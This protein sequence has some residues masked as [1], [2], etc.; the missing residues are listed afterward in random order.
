[1]KENLLTLILMMITV[2]LAGELKFHPFNDT[3]RVSLGTPVFFFF[4]LWIRKIPLIL[5][6]FMVGILVVVFRILFDFIINSGTQL[7]YDFILHSPTFFYYLT[8]ASFFSLIKVNKL[9]DRPLLVG[10][11]SVFTE[12]ISSLTELSIRHFFLE[13]TITLSFLGQI[14]II[15]VIRSFFVLGFFNIFKLHE[16]K[17][18]AKHQEKQNRHMLSLISNLYEESI[19]LKK[20]LQYAEDITRDCYNLYRNLQ[21]SDCYIKKEDLSGKLLSI[22][23]QI[24][25][26]KKDNQRIYAGLTKMISN[27]NS[28][29]YMNI[30]EIGDI[31]VQTNQKYAQSL[32][33]HI[34]ITLNIEDFPSK[35]HVYTTLS[36]INN[37]VSNSVESIENIGLIK[38]SIYKINEWIH[39]NVTDNGVGV[40]EK[41][42]EL[43]F[44]PGY[45]TKYDV[46]GKPST[47]MGLPYVKEIVSNLK[48]EISIQYTP[49]TNET[50]FII[51]LPINIL[52][53]KG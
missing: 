21:S 10:I 6:G 49:E 22:A 29:D 53:K 33:K 25:E 30:A 7:E 20:T 24:H 40:P 12:I 43:I 36:L 52:V 34:Q 16:A 1:M 38:I 4:L 45:T 8:Y 15:A 26:I 42:R 3:F 13:E 47:G 50:T 28:T 9:H 37:L 19:Q 46:S 35:F 2:P 14:I 18:T 31:I 27:E 41:K 51:K 17:L 32:N 5:F 48:G 44:K 23:G 39:F 11:T